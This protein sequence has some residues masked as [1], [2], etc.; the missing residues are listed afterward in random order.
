MLTDAALPDGPVVVRI[1]GTPVAC[2]DGVK[3]AWRDTAAFV[4]HALRLRF[5]D[6]VQWE[7]H[8]LFSPDMDHFPQ[9]VAL[10]ANGQG[11]VPLVFVGDELL[12]S[13]RTMSMPDICRRLEA[14]GCQ[15]RK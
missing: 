11:R 6:H 14:L 4:G 13:G 10:V 8:D 1:F 15:I 5:G 7:Y 9:V 12:S 3:D 2:K